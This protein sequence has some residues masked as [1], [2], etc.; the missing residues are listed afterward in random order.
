MVQAE[1]IHNPY[2]LRT[3]VSFNGRA[4]RINSQVEKYQ[5]K[6]LVD[7]ANKVPEIF[8]DEM[9]GYDFDLLFSGTPHDYKQ[10]TKAFQRAG[11]SR[12]QV[13][14][15]LKNE[16]EDADTKSQ[17]I[18]TLL[19]WLATHACRKFNE[20]QFRAEHTELF[21]SSYPYILV[22]GVIPEENNPQISI[23]RIESIDEV[24]GTDLTNTPILFYVDDETMER[25]R[26]D[27]VITLDRE[28]VSQA[29]VF[30]LFHPDLDAEKASRIIRDLGVDTPQLVSAVMDETV[31]SYF[32]NY[33]VTEYIREAI[34]L[35]EEI[36]ADISA[37]LEVE[38]RESAQNNAESHAR[39]EQLEGTIQDLK[40][41]DYFFVERDNFNQP[42]RF[43]EIEN[44]LY[45][46]VKKWKNRKTKVVGDKEADD[47]AKDCQ[48]QMLKYLSTFTDDIKKECQTV[49]SEILQTFRQKYASQGLD[50]GYSP[51]SVVFQMPVL[52]TFPPFT[53]ELIA[54]KEISF[55][56]PK[57]DIL[58]KFL[59]QSPEEKPLVIIVTC[60]YEQWRNKLL[61]LIR[62]IVQQYIQDCTEK[63]QKYYNDLAQAFHQHLRALI[64]EQTA[65]KEEVMVQLSDE[66]RAIQDDNDWFRAFKDQ[67]MQ[68]ERG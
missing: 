50:V 51:E 59:K 53:E 46:Q 45:A 9:N 21:D 38:N 19:D 60:Y 61:D 43:G 42:V 20:P 49:R 27:L 44:A 6:N 47:A 11:V 65:K 15:F 63:L 22:R 29:Q 58:N 23:E 26:Q 35:F 56:E 4:P 32:R 68:I 17:E 7:W 48:T 2:L 8:Y 31:I 67:L 40:N 34:S 36:K 55:E 33:P 62:P 10:V 13:R 64:D 16:L 14:L 18:E 28:D 41:V 37:R 25:F 3:E 39:I 30:F 57:N 12:E 52:P 5:N 1:L 24:T 66:E 54:L